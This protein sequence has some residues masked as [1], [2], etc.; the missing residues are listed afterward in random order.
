MVRLSVEKSWP[1]TVVTAIR[2]VV[3]PDEPISLTL[4]VIVVAVD[5]V[6]VT[7]LFLQ[8]F[9]VRPL[10]PKPVPLMVKVPPL[11]SESKVVESVVIDGGV[12][13]S[14]EY[15]VTPVSYTHLTL[16]TICSV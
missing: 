14:T 16:P 1:F 10:A 7:T 11:P 13:V 3:A 9:T 6:G 8:N 15:E 4:K 12:V 2:P 5:P